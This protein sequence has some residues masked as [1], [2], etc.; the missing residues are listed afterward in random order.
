MRHT[1]L[2]AVAS[3]LL[4]GTSSGALASAGCSALNGT[5][6][7]GSISGSTSGT[8]FD[9]GDTIK[10]T[11][12]AVGGS[13]RLGLYNA[14]THN[15]AILSFDT[16]GSQT[17]VV[18]EATSDELI[19][20]GTQSNSGSNFAWSCTAG[21]GANGGATDSQKLA[22]VQA[23]GST[24]VANTSGAAISTSVSTAID[25]ALGGGS[26]SP[27]TPT[28]TAMTREEYA[29]YMVQV[30]S[31]GRTLPKS[32]ADTTYTYALIN[33]GRQYLKGFV[34]VRTEDGVEWVSASSVTAGTSSQFAPSGDR[35]GV[36]ET[37]G[38]AFS[39]LS[40]ANVN[41]SLSLATPMIEQNWSAWV[42]VRGSGFQQS[43]SDLLK[44][45][46]INATVGL[47]YRLAPAVVV[48]VFGG[49]ENFDYDFAWL[50]GNLNGDGATV[51]TYAGW[52]ITPTL[53][54]KG[55]VGW[56]GLSYD[57]SAGLAAGSFDGSR[58]LLSTGI[59][60]T[61][62]VGG[63]TVEPSADVFALW[64]SQ[65]NYIDTLGGLHDSRDFSTGRV[66]LGGKVTAPHWIEGVMP[67]LGLYADWRFASDDA[68][69]ADVPD[70][71]IGDGWSARVTGGF[72]MRVLTA[73]SLSLGGE[74]GGIGADYS[75]WTG[76]ARLTVPF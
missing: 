32:L 12:T 38:D 11:V 76:T 14:T 28:I 64:E 5:F 39:A 15:P 33:Y 54:W 67:Y 47:T 43:D 69:V 48:G 37:A 42:D 34:P 60:G 7:G 25:S 8:G 44:G 13:D 66:A 46:Q 31:K 1:V 17:Y 71:G 51:G 27:S 35:T 4:M 18:P 65:G 41:K 53:R 30:E 68:V 75:V 50:T 22:S 9:A 6:S 45:T 58:W 57:A 40:Y 16:V 19:I 23:I 29:D 26:S 24:V 61:Y 21:G 55:M 56:T 49:Y 20:S 74:Y 70:T 10:L 72:S 36:S 59:N 52:Q 3:V 62:D 63:Y 73:G 2:G